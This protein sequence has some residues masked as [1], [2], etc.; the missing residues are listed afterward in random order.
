MSVPATDIRAFAR[1]GAEAENIWLLGALYSFLGTADETN[2]YLACQVRGPDGLAIPVHFHD[3]E[4]EAFYVAA[5]EVTIFLGGEQRRLSAGGFAHAPRGQEHAFRLETPDAVLLLLVSP[6]PK[7]EAMFRE[8]GEPAAAYDIPP[9]P[10]SPPDPQQLGALAAR[11][12]THMTGPP[13]TRE[14]EPQR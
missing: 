13:P 14:S 9:E 1:E 11:H 6:G 5:G 10:T 4:D 3:S 8:M 7:H 2:A 12:G